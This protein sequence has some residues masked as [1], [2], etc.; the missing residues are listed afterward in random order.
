MTDMSPGSQV[1]IHSEALCESDDIGAGTRIWAFAHIMKGATV[2]RD[3]NIGDGAFLESGARVGDRVTI[4]N[5]VM[6]WDGVEVGNDVFI[7]PGVCFTNDLSP[8]SPR[9]ELP[10]IAE[11]YRGENWLRRTR[12]ENGASLGAR[13]IVLPGIIIG[14]YAMIGAGA[15]VTRNVPTHALMAGSPAKHSGWVCRCG[16]RLCT[17]GKLHWQCTCCGENYEERTS[18]KCTNLARLS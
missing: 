11:R 7:G 13:C 12:V 1:F 6:I 9:M 5:Q 8:R 14:A 10:A 4:K 15:V 3:C 2:G 17:A 18:G 16:T